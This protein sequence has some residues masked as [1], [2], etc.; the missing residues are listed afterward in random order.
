MDDCVTYTDNPAYK[1]LQL[2]EGGF[3]KRGNPGQCFRRPFRNLL[4]YALDKCREEGYLDPIVD[5]ELMARLFLST[6][7][8]LLTDDNIVIPEEVSRQEAFGAMTVN[9][10]RG[11]S[12]EKGLKVIDEIL[13]REPRPKKLS[14]RR[15]MKNN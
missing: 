11:L 8:V 5:I 14:E 13:A 3:Y 7:G 12:T 9:F 2:R 6:T 15:E 1:V 10:L 4:Q